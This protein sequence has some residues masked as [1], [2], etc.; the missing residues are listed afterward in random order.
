[1]ETE[2]LYVLD[3]VALRQ[4]YPSNLSV[5]IPE[6]YFNHVFRFYTP[7]FID[8]DIEAKVIPATDIFHIY[9]KKVK[10]EKKDVNKDYIDCEF[11]HFSVKKTGQHTIEDGVG[12]IEKGTEIYSLEIEDEDVIKRLIKECGEK[13]I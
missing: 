6:G 13:R 3:K 5:E 9:T 2:A 12:L 4:F 10:F 7:W 8:R 1:M 11:I